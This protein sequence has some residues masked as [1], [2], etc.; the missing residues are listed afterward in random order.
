MNDKVIKVQQHIN[1]KPTGSYVDVLISTIESWR[2]L[3]P[4]T[5]YLIYNKVWV[6]T[7]TSGKEYWLTESDFRKVEKQLLS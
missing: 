2:K 5:N 3:P 1:N 7:T 6:A 4:I